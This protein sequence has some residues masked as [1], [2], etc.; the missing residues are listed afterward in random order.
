MIRDNFGLYFE[1]FLVLALAG[2]KVA[3]SS[4]ARTTH[5]DFHDAVARAANLSALAEPGAPSFHLK[6]TAEDTTMRNPEYNA[7]I[8]VWWAA[9]DRW[10][11]TVKS[12]A[13]TA[14][15]RSKRGA[16]LRI[17]FRLRLSSL[18]ARRT[19]SRLHRPNSR[20]F[21]RKRFRRR[22]STRVQ[23]LGNR[24]WLGRRTVLVLCVDLFQYGRHGTANL[25]RTHGPSIVRLP[26]V[27]Q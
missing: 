10:R 5:D 8:E 25:R 7:E 22:R 21:A 27:R 13:F 17:Q 6:L 16:L 12:P 19:H 1:F 15:R 18:L 9:P 26:A 2:A 3:S 20:R 23:K 4:A 14:D 24:P 11:R